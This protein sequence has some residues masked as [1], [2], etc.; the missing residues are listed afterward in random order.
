M[1]STQLR[2]AALLIIVVAIILAILLAFVIPI[3]RLQDQLNFDPKRGTAFN[4]IT[5][6][7]TTPGPS[8]T[9]LKINLEE[10]STMGTT[11]P[12][13]NCTHTALYWV[14]H[15]ESWPEQMVVGSQAYTKQEMLTVIQSSSVSVSNVLFIQFAAAYL[16][17]FFGA[18]PTG[19]EDVMIA[20]SEWLFKHPSGLT[21]VDKDVQQALVMVGTLENF[22]QGGMGPGPCPDEASAYSNQA[23]FIIAPVLSVTPASISMTSAVTSTPVA[24]LTP[25]PTRSSILPL[26][27]LPTATPTAT[28]KPPKHSNPK[29]KS[30]EPPPP[31]E[32]EPPPPVK[33]EPPPPPP[34][35]PPPRPTEP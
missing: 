1:E 24:T 22:N 33:T 18:D 25:S 6:A 13:P 19:I 21:L 2:L 14:Y 26:P 3:N 31:V 8:P 20:A 32:T 9:L 23:A 10:G 15:V 4:T 12:R 30:T 27:R 17:V 5:P 11:T 29:P 35:P 28:P 34:P 7:P 16:N